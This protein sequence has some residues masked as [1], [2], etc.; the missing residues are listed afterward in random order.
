MKKIKIKV[1]NFGPA[2]NSARKGEKVQLLL[3]GTTSTENGEL[4]LKY[5]D[6]IPKEIISHKDIN[7][8]PEKIESLVAIISPEGNAE[9][10]S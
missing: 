7:I 9:V 3:R 1:K 6:T 10:Y 8:S 2:L 5:L 4:H